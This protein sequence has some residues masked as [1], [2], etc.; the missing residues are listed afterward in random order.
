MV[1]SCTWLNHVQLCLYMKMQK[2]YRKADHLP[3]PYG[4]EGGTGE[5][6]V[7]YNLVVHARDLIEVG[8]NV[9]TSREKKKL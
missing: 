3:Q 6:E 5:F 9:T 8:V 2:S 4:H 7:K 1:K